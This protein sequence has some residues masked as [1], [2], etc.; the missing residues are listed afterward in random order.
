MKTVIKKDVYL[1]SPKNPLS[2]NA[3]ECKHRKATN[4]MLHSIF[5]SYVV[6]VW[7][8]SV[9]VWTRSYIDKIVTVRT[10]LEQIS[11]LAFLTA[12]QARMIE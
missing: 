5:F 7:T 8:F 12:L 1:F 4:K 2:V 10:F 9:T 3:K 11:M 6:T